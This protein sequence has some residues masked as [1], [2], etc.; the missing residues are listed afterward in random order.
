MTRRPYPTVKSVTMKITNC[1]WC[2]NCKTKLTKGFGY[3]QDYYC[4]A[5]PDKFVIAAYV[6]WGS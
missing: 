1:T 5:T 4:D 6:E 2:P 3:A